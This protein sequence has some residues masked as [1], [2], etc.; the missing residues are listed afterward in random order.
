MDQGGFETLVTA[1]HGEIYRYLLRATGR[2]SDAADL[3]QETFLRAYRAFP[4]LPAGAN[5]RA[6]LFTIATNLSRNHFRSQQRRRVAYAA[7][8]ATA[9]EAA[10]TGPEAAALSR[11]AH[12]R[13]EAAVGRLPFKQRAAFLQRKVHGLDYDAIAQ[14]LRCS[15]EAAR[16]HVFQALRKIRRALNGEDE[17][18]RR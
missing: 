12:A 13:L 11:E 5:T 4:A 16:A 9:R 8:G 2:A 3:S 17:E 14:S 15:P 1:H 10:D 7:V 6:W 18:G